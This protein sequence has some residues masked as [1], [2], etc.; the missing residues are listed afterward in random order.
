LKQLGI[1]PW[2]YHFETAV[3]PFTAIT[4]AEDCFSRESVRV[5]LDH[6]LSNVLPALPHEKATRLRKELAQDNIY[7][8]AICDL[9][10]HLNRPRGRTIAKGRLLKHLKREGMK[11]GK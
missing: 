4:I 11:L 10:D 7:G 5:R 9:R 1:T 2:I 8:V 6:I 3:S